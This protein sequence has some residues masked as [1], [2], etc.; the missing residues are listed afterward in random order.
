MKITI[1]DSR[2]LIREPGRKEPLNGYIVLCVLILAWLEH[3]VP[4]K[5]FTHPQ[6]F[7][8]G[9][10]HQLDDLTV[11]RMPENLLSMTTKDTLLDKRRDFKGTSENPRGSK[12]RLNY[13]FSP[14]SVRLLGN[15]DSSSSPEDEVSKTIA[16]GPLISFGASPEDQTLDANSTQSEEFINSNK[17]QDTQGLMI[18]NLT[19][20]PLR[21][22]TLPTFIKGASASANVS[23]RMFK[24]MK[25]PLFRRGHIN[26]PRQR[27]SLR[28]HFPSDSEEYYSYGEP[29]QYDGDEEEEEVVDEGEEEVDEGQA[30]QRP[31]GSPDRDSNFDLPVLGSRAQHD[32]ALAIYATD[33]KQS[34]SNGQTRS[35]SL[36]E[37]MMKIGCA[38]NERFV[39]GG[40]GGDELSPQ[41]SGVYRVRRVGTNNPEMSLHRNKR[42]LVGTRD[43]WDSLGTSSGNY[44]KLTDPDKNSP[45]AFREM[46]FDEVTED[47]KTVDKR[48]IRENHLSSKTLTQRMGSQV[49]LETKSGRKT[50]SESDARKNISNVAENGV[51]EDSD[52][53]SSGEEVR[54]NTNTMS[55]KRRYLPILVPRRKSSSRNRRTFNRLIEAKKDEPKGIL[56]S[57]SRRFLDMAYDVSTIEPFSSHYQEPS[58]NNNV[59]YDY[60]LD[61]K[62]KS[63]WKGRDPSTNDQH[64]FP[65]SDLF[66]QNQKQPKNMSTD[67][68]L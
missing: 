58:Q 53:S 42:G 19:F 13:N 5:D 36:P 68:A 51:S 39:P 17:R 47:T 37:V 31:L 3:H 57:Q 50:S 48:L 32:S 46:P 24:V 60:D 6:R 35:N 59:D 63:T 10:S 2:R 30:V 55:G 41:L 44:S 38:E 8:V 34:I 16:E 23:S 40:P 18:S 7:L 26:S 14:A 45:V 52:S 56:L 20:F 25:R 27:L 11:A 4:E 65:D 54:K 61:A 62:M 9:S 12:L 1:L 29:L 28:S 67:E 15:N 66:F 21:N 64:F 43:L 22:Q 49:R 33:T